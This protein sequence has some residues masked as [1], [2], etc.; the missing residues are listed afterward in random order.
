M[1]ARQCCS[2]KVFCATACG[3][4]FCRGATAPRTHPTGA[5]GAPEAPV[6][7]SGGGRGGSPPGEAARAGG[8]LRGR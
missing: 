7:G 2:I 3:G 4:S 5:S 6:W 1:T 8:A